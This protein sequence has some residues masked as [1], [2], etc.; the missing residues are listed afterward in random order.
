MKYGNISD[1]MKRFI[2]LICPAIPLLIKAQDK[3]SL[4][5][6]KLSAAGVKM[7]TVRDGQYKV[8]T[9]KINSGKNK[10][11]LLAGGPGS[12]FEYFENFPLYLKDNYEI[13]FYSQLGSYLSDQPVDSTLQTVN[14]YVAEVEE[15]RKALGLENFYILGHSW[16]ARLAL[17]YTAKHQKH[18]KGLILSN[19]SGLGRGLSDLKSYEQQLLADVVAGIPEFK[20]Y[21]DSIRHGMTEQTHPELMAGIMKQARPVYVKRHFMR[22]DTVP[23][24]VYR[25]RIH[26]NEPKMRWLTMDSQKQDPLPLFA[27]IKVPTLFIGGRYDYIPP[28]SYPIARSLMKNN[29]DVTIHITPNGSHRAMWDDADNYFAAI[30]SF[31]ERTNKKDK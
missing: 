13:Y 12:S 5:N 11:L 6:F 10:L 17:A 29:K 30:K 18:V 4:A 15:V 21:A 2:L 3:D 16:A 19:G 27:T 8:W 14:G 31:V 23:D 9:Q 22:L 28:G 7:I 25:S 1:I 26:S 20:M 24:A